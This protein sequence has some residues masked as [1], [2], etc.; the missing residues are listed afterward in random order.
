MPLH[1]CARMCRSVAL[2]WT[3]ALCLAS[4]GARARVACAAEEQGRGAL[5]SGSVSLREAVAAALLHSPDLATYSFE[6]RAQEARALQEGLLPNP[7]LATEVEN[8]GRFGGSGDV[9]ST[10]TTVSLIQLFE[11]GGKRGKRASVA[12]LEGR[13]AG[14]EYERAR[15]DTAAKAL[16]AFVGGLLAQERLVLADRLLELA[17]EVVGAVQRQVDAGAGSPVELIRAEASLAQVEASRARREGEYRAARVAL[18]ATWGG[19]TADFTRLDGILEPPS[20]PRPLEDFRE[21]LRENPDLARWATAVERARAGVALEESRRV[22][23]V[24]VRFGSRRFVS[25]ET[26]A[27]VAELSVPLPIFNR[28]QGAVQEAY[29]RLGKTHAEQHAATVL[30]DATLSVT[31]EGLVAAF[32]QAR[33]LKDRVL[34][35]TQTALE[36]TRRA[37][38]QGVVRYLDVLDA[39]RS[40]SE[41]QGDYLEALARYHAAAADLERLAGISVTD[42]ARPAK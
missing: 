33:Q 13:L 39:Q 19:T 32:E 5:P 34:P 25:A 42:A 40:V 38:A 20:A 16:K 17:H 7:S 23:D 27:F 1:T 10:Q 41:L 21:Q 11:L 12:R 24:T 4:I 29:E 22:P 31:Y 26:N 2:R 35:R 9:E 30:A 15:L 8:F 37:Y 6:V 3:I 28:N 18:A 36:A 14:W